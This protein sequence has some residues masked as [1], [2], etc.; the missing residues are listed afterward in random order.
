MTMFE[1][2]AEVMV[3]LMALK[4]VDVEMVS[5]WQ[6]QKLTLPKFEQVVPF[7]DLYLA[8]VN[9]NTIN[10]LDNSGSNETMQ[11]VLASIVWV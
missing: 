2:A 5:S 4:Q 6:K 11:K 7:C 9:I 8:D 10:I 1:V 3:V